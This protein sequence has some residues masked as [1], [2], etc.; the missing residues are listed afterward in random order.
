MSR[1]LKEFSEF[2][3]YD[4][5]YQGSCQIAVWVKGWDGWI[6]GFWNT[7]TFQRKNITEN[8]ENAFPTANEEH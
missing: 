7:Q 4:L 8:A 1:L 2:R 5:I 3:D 6:D